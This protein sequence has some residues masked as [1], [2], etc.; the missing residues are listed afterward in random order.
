MEPFIGLLREVNIGQ[1]FIMFAGGWA[2]YKRLDAKI[3]GL[4]DRLDAR[5]DKLE[6]RINATENS[7]NNKIE[8]SG[9]KLEIKIDRLNEK[10]EDVDRR[11]CKIEG[12]L[13]LVRFVYHNSTQKQ[14]NKTLEED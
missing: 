7:L 12:G 8:C 9:N 10:V 3:S 1:I 4:G 5:I 13:D 11:L 2:F 14:Q 6:V